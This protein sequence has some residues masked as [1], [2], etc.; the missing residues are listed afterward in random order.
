[1]AN[2]VGLLDMMN[3]IGLF[4]HSI[5]SHA[6]IFQTFIFQI[7]VPSSFTHFESK[8]ASTHSDTV[9]DQVVKSGFD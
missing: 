3:V 8:Q 9:C 7:L 6:F 1:M 4:S 2:I 5:T